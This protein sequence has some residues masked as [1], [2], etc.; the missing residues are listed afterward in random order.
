MTRYNV[1]AVLALVCVATSASASSYYWDESEGTKATYVFRRGY[2]LTP[3]V[4]YTFETDNLSSGAWTVMY[5]IHDS[6]EVAHNDSYAGSPRSRISY[7]APW[8]PLSPT[9]MHIVLVRAFAN[10]FGGNG[11]KAFDFKFNGVLVG[12]FRL[13][14][15]QVQLNEPNID[16]RETVETVL[17]ND[18]AESTLLIRFEHDGT[19]WKYSAMDETSGVGAASKLSGSGA[20]YQL[21]VIGTPAPAVREGAVRLVRNDKALADSDADGLGD[22][23]EG[24]LCT[25]PRRTASSCGI[26]CASVPNTQDIDGDGLKDDWEVLGVDDPTFPQLLPRWGAS[27]RH[28]DIFVEVDYSNYTQTLPNGGEKYGTSPQL[29]EKEAQWAADRYAQLYNVSNPDGVTGVRL[30]L[31]I[32]Q[33]CTSE[34]DDVD[35]ISR[36]CGN[37]GGSNYLAERIAPTAGGSCGQY[38]AT[39]YTPQRARLFRWA[40]GQY[41]PLP[42]QP[43]RG[44][45]GRQLCFDTGKSEKAAILAHE[46]GHTLGL[47]HWG[48]DAA[49]KMNRKAN[50]PSIMSY[51]FSYALHGRYDDVAF[52]DGSRAP[53]DPMNL[54]ETTDYSGSSTDISFM[55][56]EVYKFPTYLFQPRWIDWNRDGHFAPSVRANIHNEPNKKDYGGEEMPTFLDQAP[57][58]GARTN[59]GPGA[60]HW[61]M[62]NPIEN[63]IFDGQWVVINEATTHTFRYITGYGGGFGSEW[64]SMG[65]TTFRP[66][67]EPSLAVFTAFG[68]E[69]LYVFGALSSGPIAYARFDEYGAGG[70]WTVLNDPAPGVS[71]KDVSVARLGSRLWLVGRDMAT[72][73]LWYG[74]LNSTLNFSGWTRALIAGASIRADVYSP[75]VAAGPDGRL[76]VLLRADSGPRRGDLDLYVFNPTGASWTQ[77]T[78]AATD[79]TMWPP[80]SPSNC[81]VDGRPGLVWRPHL[82]AGGAPLATGNGALWMWYPVRGTA[83][84]TDGSPEANTY[85]R[86]TTGTFNASVQAFKMGRWQYT[87]F[88]ECHVDETPG[89]GIA[90]ASPPDGL[91]AFVP[92]TGSAACPDRVIVIPHADGMYSPPHL[93]RDNDDHA[94]IAQHLCLALND[95][96]ACKCDDFNSSVPCPAASMA[97]LEPREPDV[98]VGP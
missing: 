21:Y 86:Q 46:L 45:F 23:L 50:Y 12:R 40:M 35:G 19:H 96:Q 70:P 4:P 53:L 87:P 81:Q 76:Y 48:S 67:S 84:H 93:I 31:D 41:G 30:H 43:G 97:Q 91:M 77:W 85:F 83:C 65:A 25:C 92:N 18:G 88:I 13:G 14:G 42:D 71:F 56:N 55:T 60:I 26:S 10:A 33:A 80:D 90:L 28:K 34:P 32:G 64:R 78:H 58:A 69:R 2:C 17:V 20:E 1:L 15:Y 73:E 27:P 72:Q 7:T 29:T 95:G 6:R 3:G 24:E 11:G 89:A 51:G 38:K 61:R 74:S 16:P 59:V 62:N 49:G 57:L 36:V 68:G 98:C 9:C 37:L 22:S 54:S 79:S 5:L 44:P 94:T 82:T 47:K 63:I 8:S 75:G 52:S 66:D 39:N